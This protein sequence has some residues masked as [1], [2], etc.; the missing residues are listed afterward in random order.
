MKF[1]LV[2]SLPDAKPAEDLA[3]DFVWGDFAGDGAEVVEGGAEILG[4]E[5][6]SEAGGEGRA[7]RGEGEACLGKGLEVP[8]IGHNRLVRIESKVFLGCG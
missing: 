4:D 2:R 3:Q 1:R 5:V 7:S 8:Q 6:R